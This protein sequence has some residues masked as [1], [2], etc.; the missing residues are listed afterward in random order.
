MSDY[1][2]ETATEEVVKYIPVVGSLLAASPSY[3]K[4][5]WLLGQ[6]LDKMHIAANRVFGGV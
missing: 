1:S 4:T 2:A 3:L 5:R 6:I